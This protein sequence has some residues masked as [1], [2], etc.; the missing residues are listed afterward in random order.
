M[1]SAPAAAD[2]CPAWCLGE[3][4]EEIEH[5]SARVP[6]GDLVAELIRY[7]DSPQVYL[8]LLEPDEG[9]RYLL[10]P[11]SVVPLIATVALRL[12]A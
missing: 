11:M 12:S 6:V 7:P 8:S 2:R 9:G 1:V 3:H 4:R 5:H 10:L